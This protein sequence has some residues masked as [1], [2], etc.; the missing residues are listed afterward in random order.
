MNGTFNVPISEHGPRDQTVR[1]MC[2]PPR[3]H[4]FFEAK[5]VRRHFFHDYLLLIAADEHQP[6]HWWWQR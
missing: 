6:F 2:E 3:I 4:R 1:P 5:N